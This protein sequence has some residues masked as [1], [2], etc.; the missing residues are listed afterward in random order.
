MNLPPCGGT[1]GRS[2]GET[3][4]GRH[5]GPC[6]VGV[7]RVPSSNSVSIGLCL[8]THSFNTH[9]ELWVPRTHA[10]APRSL[11]PLCELGAGAQ[12][13]A[14]AVVAVAVTLSPSPVPG[15]VTAPTP[16]ALAAPLL[17]PVCMGSALWPWRLP[18]LPRSGG[19]WPWPPLSTWP[20]WLFLTEVR[21]AQALGTSA[22]WQPGRW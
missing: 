16:R 14:A 6:H 11:R 21:W 5:T 7:P 19:L 9:S 10:P 3:E 18:S 2:R 4:A 22:R 12:R 17:P 13:S 15:A 20:L 8:H 1:W